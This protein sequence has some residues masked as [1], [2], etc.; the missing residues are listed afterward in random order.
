M[1]N[2]D[3]AIKDQQ[4]I[5]TEVL[6]ENIANVVP[7]K[8]CKQLENP[9]ENCIDKVQYCCHQYAKDARYNL[10][11]PTVKVLDRLSKNLVEYKLEGRKLGHPL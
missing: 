4:S 5:T 6:G 1:K 9:I 3:A 11:S 8:I 10:K 2:F 7:K